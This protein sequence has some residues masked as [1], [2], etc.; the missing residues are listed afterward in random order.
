LLESRAV[1]TME[2]H[3]ENALA[4]SKNGEYFASGGYDR[5]LLVW[6]SQENTE[7]EEENRCDEETIFSTACRQ[8]IGEQDN[9]TRVN[10][11]T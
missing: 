7:R 5:Q 11:F 1:F 6:Q 9:L 3:R 2:G 4:C 10:F 8:C